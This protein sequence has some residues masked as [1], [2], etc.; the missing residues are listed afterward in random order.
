MGRVEVIGVGVGRLSPASVTRRVSPALSS[1]QLATK[2]APVGWGDQVRS[3]STS[4]GE[5]SPASGSRPARLVGVEKRS[6]STSPAL[7]TWRGPA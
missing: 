6:V 5:S 4:S 7:K 2:A 3:A 1:L